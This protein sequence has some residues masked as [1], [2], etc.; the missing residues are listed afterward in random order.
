MLELDHLCSS[1]DG[2]WT[3]TIDTLQHQ[4][5]SLMSSALDLSTTSAIYIPITYIVWWYKTLYQVE[6][7]VWTSITTSRESWYKVSYQHTVYAIS[8]S[9]ISI[10]TNF[11]QKTRVEIRL[12]N[13]YNILL[14]TT[15]CFYLILLDLL[16]LTPLSA[17]F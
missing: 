6:S 1:L 3:H 8:L 16:C 14:E 7:V 15:F 9:I 10:K 5:P 4:S 17:L 2:I 11:K 12:T 13:L